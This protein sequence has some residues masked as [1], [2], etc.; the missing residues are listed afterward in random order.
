MA[1]DALDRAVTDAVERSEGE[2]TLVV[3]R[4]NVRN[5]ASEDMA[6]RYG[7]EP[8][9][10]GPDEFNPGLRQWYVFADP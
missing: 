1:N 4:I 5:K 9:S 8:L 2:S 10:D 7:F 6:R 3:G